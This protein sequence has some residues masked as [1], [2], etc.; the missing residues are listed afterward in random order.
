MNF[1]IEDSVQDSQNEINILN[2]Q[3]QLPL[4]NGPYNQ[5]DA[6]TIKEV[7]INEEVSQSELKSPLQQ[8]RRKKYIIISIIAVVF[9]LLIGTVS[10][11]LAF[12]KIPRSEIISALIPQPFTENNDFNYFHLKNKLKVMI[13]KPN[14]GIS[15]SFIC[16]LISFDGWRWLRKRSERFHWFHA[17]NRTFALHRVQKFSRGASH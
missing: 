9:I 15:H 1:E 7:L 5:A 10:L 8:S 6:Q 17:F 14:S 2:E 16:D 4:S 3:L 11:L 12:N 13:V